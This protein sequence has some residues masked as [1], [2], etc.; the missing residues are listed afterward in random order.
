MHPSSPPRLLSFHHEADE[1][2]TLL[3]R[4][5]MLAT[6]Y[7]QRLQSLAG[8]VEPMLCYLV[9]FFA[10]IIFTYA[11]QAASGSLPDLEI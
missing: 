5:E 10:L 3:V 4:G 8:K 9:W 6:F 11:W 2:L 1:V 7:S